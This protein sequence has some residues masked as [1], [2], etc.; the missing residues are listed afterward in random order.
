[1]TLPPGP[2]DIPSGAP[3]AEAEPAIVIAHP[4]ASQVSA[5]IDKALF[6]PPSAGTIG[7]MELLRHWDGL[8]TEKRQMLLLLAREMCQGERG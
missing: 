2:F 4:A 5:W 3:A 8:S 7:R 1:M 6:A